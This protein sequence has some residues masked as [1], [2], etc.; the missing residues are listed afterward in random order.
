M[1]AR[2]AFIVFGLAVFGVG[3]LLGGW[4]SL[5]VFLWL[6]A[7]TMSHEYEVRRYGWREL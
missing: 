2:V 6:N 4:L 7:R 1:M 3:F 5:S